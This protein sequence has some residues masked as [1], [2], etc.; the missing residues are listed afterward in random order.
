METGS[1]TLSNC[2]T[3][4]ECG[5]SGESNLHFSTFKTYVL[6]MLPFLVFN[7]LSKFLITWWQHPVDQ[8]FS[9]RP[10]P[11][12]SASTENILEVPILG[13]H[14]RPTESETER[15]AQQSVFLTRSPGDSDAGDCLRTGGSPRGHVKMQILCKVGLGKAWR[16]C[17]SNKCLGSKGV[18]YT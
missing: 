16:V 15:W 4:T 17:I 11:V 8:S 12:T 13:P 7:Q 3:F 2:L 10:G 5:W 9:V 14:L 1:E 18:N 6:Y